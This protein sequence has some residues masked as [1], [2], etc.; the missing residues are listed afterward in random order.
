M[1]REKREREE[2]Q[3]A[4]C[5]SSL[6]PFSAQGLPELNVVCS[7]CVATLSRFLFQEL[8]QLP[9][10]C[11]ETFSVQNT[12]QQAVPHGHP[13]SEEPLSFACFVLKLGF[14]LKQASLSAPNSCAGRDRACF[15]QCAGEN[16]FKRHLLITVWPEK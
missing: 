8:L 6:Q 3:Y 5:S 1:H 12:M 13:L 15:C 16:H 4:R 11:M 2:N 10:E 7:T 9:L 14:T